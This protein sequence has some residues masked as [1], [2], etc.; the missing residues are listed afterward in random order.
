[1]RNV[2]STCDVVI[3]TAAVPGKKAPILVTEDMVAAMKT[4]SVIVDMAVEQGGNVVG[5]KPGEK[6]NINGVT[7]IGPI[8]LPSRMAIH[9]SQLFARNVVTLFKHLLQEGQLKLDFEDEITAGAV[10]TYEGEVVNERTK[11][12]LS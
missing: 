4:G 7:I 2:L 1:L 11:E 3:T 12:L 6:V 10:I 5:S 8:N 9:T